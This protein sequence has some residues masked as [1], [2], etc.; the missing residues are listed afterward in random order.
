MPKY[1][2]GRITRANGVAG[3]FCLSTEVTYEG[4]EPRVLA[5]IG[6]TYGGPIV[7]RTTVGGREFQTFV[8][9]PERFGHVLSTEWVANFLAKTGDDL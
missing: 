3:Q 5:F 1:T 8:R 7:M 2:H 6:S 9:E 4:E